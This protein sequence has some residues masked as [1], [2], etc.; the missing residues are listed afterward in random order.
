LREKWG[1]RLRFTERI[2]TALDDLIQQRWILPED[3]EAM[4]HRAEQEWD[5]ATK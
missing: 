3:R 2:P 1:V 5:E 4:L